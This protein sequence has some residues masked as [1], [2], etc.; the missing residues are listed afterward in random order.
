MKQT[1]HWYILFVANEIHFWNNGYPFILLR[2][3]IVKKDNDR[4]AKELKEIQILREEREKRP[5]TAEAPERQFKK[6][7]RLIPGND[8]CI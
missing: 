5:K 8:H 4:L 7:S 1:C 3:A 6:D 2:I